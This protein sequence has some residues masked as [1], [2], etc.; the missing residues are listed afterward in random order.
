MLPF[1]QAA[2]E[3]ISSVEG[4]LP[5]CHDDYVKI[6]GLA[7]PTIPGDYIFLDE[8]QDTAPVFLDILQQQQVPI[9]LVGDECQIIYEWRGAINAAAAYPDAEVRY[10]TQSF[11]FGQAIADVANSILE[12]LEK[13]VQ[14]RLKGLSSIPSTVAP[15]GKPDCILTRTN[16]AAVGTFLRATAEGQRPFLVGG[17]K[18]VVSFVGAARDLQQGRSTSHPDLGCFSTW[19]EVQEYAATDDGEDLKL[20]VKLIDAYTAETILAGLKGMPAEKDADL[21]ISTAHKSKGREWDTVQLAGDFPVNSFQGM[22]EARPTGLRTADDSDRRLLYVAATR[23]KKTLDV[24]GCP[25][26]TGET[27]LNVIFTPVD[28]A[29]I[30]GVLPAA[31]VAAPKPE[32]FTWSKDKDGSWLVRGP[33][34]HKGESVEVVRK[35]GSTSRKRLGEVVWDGGTVA[36][37]RV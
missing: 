37:Y 19:T 17:T 2:W 32:S 22:P 4:K 21:V 13:P 5:F 1:A 33:T 28:S 15:V 8:D 26:F 9:V 20:W 12:T 36:T 34:G 10:L 3:D 35:D 6:W 31:P 29:P 23:A 18:E 11:R 24:S 14:L 16:A 25:F 27:G 30:E 7:G